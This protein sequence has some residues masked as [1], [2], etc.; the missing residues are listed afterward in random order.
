MTWET[1]EHAS[2]KRSNYH[3]FVYGNIHHRLEDI[4]TVL[5]EIRSAQNSIWNKENI[6]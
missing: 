1:S 2:K 3:N 4:N 5:V 6:L